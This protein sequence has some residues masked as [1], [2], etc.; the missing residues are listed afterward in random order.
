MKKTYLLVV[1]F[2]IFFN[3]S[4][5]VGINTDTPEQALDV[6]GKLK[7]GDDS[8]TPNEGSMR[9]NFTTKAFEGFNGTEWLNLSPD[10][11]LKEYVVTAPEFN[12]FI[13][14]EFARKSSIGT[15]Y[16]GA[17]AGNSFNHYFTAGFHLPLGAQVESITYFYLDLR[18]DVDIQFNIYSNCG[19]TNGVS[20]FAAFKTSGSLAEYR[21]DSVST[22]FTINSNCGY[23]IRA[24]I[25]DQNGNNTGGLSW[26]ANLQVNKVIVK[27]R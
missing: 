20:S 15:Y 2:F 22:N 13:D 10:N 26:D 7:I 25:V 4:A 27:Y 3:L 8:N 12:A 24:R 17:P 16:S 9:Y 21:L 19:A 5:Q 6:N 11:S 1:S 18:N 14:N 23:I